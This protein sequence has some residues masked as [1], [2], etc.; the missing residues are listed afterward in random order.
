MAARVRSGAVAGIDGCAV[1]VEVDVSRGLPGFHVVGLP[2]TAVK[3]SR[4]RVLAALRHAGYRFPAGRVTVNLAPA[5]VR[6]EGA[7][8]DLAIALGVILAQRRA[9]GRR[10]AAAEALVVGELSLFGDVRPVR[11]LLAIVLD[12]AARGERRV[13]VPAGQAW[14]AHLVGG[15]EVIPVDS[16]AEAARWLLDGRVPA[17]PA[18]PSAA[19]IPARRRADDAQSEAVL[20]SLAGQD[21]ARRA[22]I[23]AAAG[24]HHL[25]LVG[26]PGAGKTRLARAVA[27]LLP[28]L[29]RSAALEV[30]R[31]HGAAGTL[32]A[33]GLL[34]RPPLRAPHHTITRAGLV[35]GGPALRP[36][37]MTLAHRGVLFLDEVTEF[38]APVIDALRE[39][40]EAGTVT[41]ARSGGH[42]AFP[43]RFQLVAAMNPC[44]CG[45]LGSRR[46]ACRC[47]ASVQRRYRQRLSGPLLDRFDLCVEMSEPETDVLAPP[48]RGPERGWRT[49]PATAAIRAA[50]ARRRAR[51]DLPESASL[52]RR[53]AQLGL[54]GA[55]RERLET[56]R[57]HLNL[58]LRAVLRCARV[59]ATIAALDGSAH[60]DRA[61]I[62]EAL[63]FRR[64]NVP[65]LAGNPLG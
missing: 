26:P 21:L 48:P 58:S 37:E 3:E 39:P 12:A 18:R 43:A 57:R 60:A 54:D 33:A 22:A 8:Y 17:P 59:A 65:V 52:A 38:A 2:N 24:G 20:A 51:P 41:V 10:E 28:P 56:A 42:R 63:E 32:T 23:I 55:A 4:E 9:G 50:R 1:T 16:L 35:G 11:G 64:D 25:L 49:G 34:R 47:T 19:P 44:R 40:L 13:V 7:S 15:L 6:K 36:G 27:G 30:T 14:E 61:V 29:E 62:E 31:I 45:Y 5:D 46:R 53:V